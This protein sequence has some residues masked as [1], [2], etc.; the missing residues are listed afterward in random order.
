[1]QA[2]GEVSLARLAL[3]DGD[4]THAAEHV[5]AALVFE[6]GLPEAHE[7]LARLSGAPDGG[8]GLFPMEEPVFLG[9]VLARAHLLAARG[10]HAEALD[11]L[12]SAQAHEMG[13][14]WAHVPWVLDPELASRIDPD[15]LC[16][17]IG[18][19]AAVMPDPLPEGEREPLA[20][21]VQLVRHAV[22]L[23]PDHPMLLW[24]GSMLVRRAGEP[25]EAAG[26]AERSYRL[27]PSMQA[28]IAA[29]YA[30]RNLERWPEAERALVRA[31]EH[32]PG[33]L[34]LH[35]DIGE[36]LHRAGRL[37][38]GLAW[39]E[40]ALRRDPAHESAFPTARGMRFERDG[41]VRHL[42][43]LAN[44]LREH[45][46]NEH[47]DSVL[48]VHSAPRDWL[49]R[50]PA[51]SEAV[52]NLLYQVLE[53]AGDAP[54]TGEAFLSAPEPPSAL[55]AF[56]RVLPGYSIEIQDVPAPDARLTVPEVFEKG[57]VRSVGRRVWHFEG[58]RAVPVVP[59]PSP[60]AARAVAAL[61]ESPW[62]H[63]P[64]AYDQAVRLSALPL[65]DLLGVLVHPPE[66]P[67]DRPEVWPQWLRQVQAWACFGIAHHRPDQPWAESD[68]R[69]V[70]IDL[71]YGP[72]D[73]ITEAALAA[74]VA[75]AWVNPEARGDVAELVGWRFMAA[76]EAAT[77]RPVTIL[78]SLRALVLAT[79]DMHP[80]LRRLA[81]PAPAPPPERPRSRWRR[82]FRRR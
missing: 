77:T 67:F 46:G 75:T 39:V 15:T 12:V 51:A 5:A 57:A 70:L 24:A 23:Y 44:Y 54:A 73:W 59:P 22:R 62:R 82:L 1:M 14:R 7:L 26:L 6:P 45:P 78:D 16:S 20:P 68:R 61:A 29:G 60:E 33:N 69:R 41:D 35:T 64:G 4:V 58:T 17:L 72:E 28:A 32:D 13:G 53:K 55:L 74:L 63:L 49:G 76:A 36:L 66:C 31:L 11:L 8:A 2:E 65:D 56:A 52:V 71:A 21:Y 34:Y 18:S 47:A 50:A 43:E 27:E 30:Y 81:A 19:L 9:T 40:R 37:D 38:D 42:V 80:D 3:D 25:G 79:P 10:E 48:A